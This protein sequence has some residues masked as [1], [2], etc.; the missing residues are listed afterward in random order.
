MCVSIYIVGSKW[1]DCRRCREAII[2]IKFMGVKFQYIKEELIVSSTLVEGQIILK[3]E[4]GGLVL[5][6]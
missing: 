5:W 1:A 2:I 6:Q 4:Y 3:G